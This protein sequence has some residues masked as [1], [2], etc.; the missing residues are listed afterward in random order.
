MLSPDTFSE[1]NE[2]C[3]LY[4]DASCQLIG[5]CDYMKCPLI[6]WVDVYESLTR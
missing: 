3:P 1:H 2:E 6:Y 4:A 5:V